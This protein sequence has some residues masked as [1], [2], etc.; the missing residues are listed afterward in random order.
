ME[1]IRAA[2]ILSRLPGCGAA[3][4]KGLLQLYKTPVK[5]LRAFTGGKF[6]GS[7]KYPGKSNL[8]SEVEYA[9]QGISQ[10]KYIALWYGHKDYPQKLA[11]LKE[12]PPVLFSLKKMVTGNCAGIVGARKITEASFPLVKK[13]ARKLVEQGFTIISGAAAGIDAQAHLAAIKWGGQTLAVLGNGIEVNYPKSNSELFKILREEHNL[14]SELLPKAKPHKGFFPTRNRII[15]GLSDFVVVVQAAE[16]SGSMITAKW[17]EKLERPVFTITPPTDSHEWN[18][19]RKLLHSG[20][21][22]FFEKFG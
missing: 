9:L 10:T 5:A 15:A 11:Q 7:I 13:I 3:T 21:V 2:L 20:A 14:V 1:N 18:G 17:A 16:K 4:F 19:N 6:N 12:P 8:N 22:D